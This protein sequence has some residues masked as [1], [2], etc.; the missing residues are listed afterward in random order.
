MSDERIITCMLPQG[1][2]LPLQ[3][4]LFRELGLAR[5]DL[6]SARGFIGSDPRGLF[7]RIQRD[8][9]AVLVDEA[10]ADEVFGWIYREAG[11][12]EH[13]GRF[14]Y[15]ARASHATPFALPAGIPLEDHRPRAR[16]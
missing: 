16:E 5:V 12:A 3:N 13:E 11:V 6:H 8:V 10:Q 9:H 7:N 4:R 1:A 15:V 14:L 2:G